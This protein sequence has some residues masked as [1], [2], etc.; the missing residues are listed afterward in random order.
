MAGIG[1]A[2]RIPSFDAVGGGIVWND[3]A[4]GIVDIVSNV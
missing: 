3:D 2:L 4:A 1:I